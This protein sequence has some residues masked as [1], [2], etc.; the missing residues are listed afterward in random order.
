MVGDLYLDRTLEFGPSIF[1]IPWYSDTYVNLKFWSRPS[2][3]VFS[4]SILMRS[5]KVNEAEEETISSG[6]N[7]I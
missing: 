2:F 5:L 7:A 3:F 6:T 4:S 1:Q